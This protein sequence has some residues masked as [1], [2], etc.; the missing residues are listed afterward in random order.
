MADRIQV[1]PANLRAA[2]AHH[3]ETA[4]YLRAIPS[5]HEAIAQSLDSLGPVFSE[6]R[7]A[8]LELL[9]QRRR[10]YE[11]LADSH[12]EIAHDLTTSASLWEQHDDLSAGEFK[13]I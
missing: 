12:A 11:Q 1:V 6:L 7:E 4:D 2:A 8:G 5:T 3:E 13:R 9:E 10:S